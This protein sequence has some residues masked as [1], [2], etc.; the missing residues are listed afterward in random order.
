MSWKS[1]FGS[2]AVL[3]FFATAGFAQDLKSQVNVEGVA[4]ITQSNNNFL[5]PTSATVGGGFLAGYRYNLS[6]LFAVEGDYAWMRNSQSFN[7]LN[8][9]S[10][11]QTNVQELTGAAVLTPGSNHR[12]RPYLM[13]GGGAVFFHPTNSAI[14][15]LLGL[16]SNVGVNVNET[17][18][19]FLYGGG[20]DFDLTRYMALRAEYRGLLFKAPG[21]EIPG[22]SGIPVLGS[23]TSSGFT[24][25]AQ[26]AVGLV[27]RF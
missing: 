12:V 10:G 20:V 8:I 24:H 27:W 3:T 9:G 17:K 2:L 13:A 25:M 5:F 19:A 11:I 26:P 4:G 21:L 1:V 7:I 22:L 6:P 23:L 15:T 16:G 18:P 14:N